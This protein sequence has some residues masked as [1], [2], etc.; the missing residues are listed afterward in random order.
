MDYQLFEKRKRTLR[1]LVVTKLFF[2]YGAKSPDGRDRRP[3]PS[4]LEKSV[5]NREWK[6]QQRYGISATWLFG[7]KSARIDAGH[8]DIRRRKRIFQSLGE[9]RCRGSEAFCGSLPGSRREHVRHRGR[10]FGRAF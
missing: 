1:L 6:N 4:G 3:L 5:A 2:A 8:G 7:I 9:C 10:V